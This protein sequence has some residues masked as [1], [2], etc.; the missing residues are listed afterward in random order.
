M[1]RSPC[2]LCFGPDVRR[3][4]QVGNPR[5]LHHRRK[6]GALTRRVVSGFGRSER[7]LPWRGED[8]VTA[9]RLPLSILECASISYA[10]DKCLTLLC[11]TR[12]AAARLGWLVTSLWTTPGPSVAPHFRY[13]YDVRKL[14]RGAKRTRRFHPSTPRRWTL[15]AERRPSSSSFRTVC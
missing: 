4:H 5:P 11:S 10:W 12:H 13:V 9:S 14:A 3:G 8:S 6:A 2:V 7:A 1:F 15:G